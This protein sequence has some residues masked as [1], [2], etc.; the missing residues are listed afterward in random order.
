MS[1]G[2]ALA[3]LAAAID[4][5][6]TALERLVTL[7][8]TQRTITV[9]ALRG[10]TIEGRES[11]AIEALVAAGA[12]Q[13][14]PGQLGTSG[15]VDPTRAAQVGELLEVVLEARASAV[16]SAPAE[17]V[18][19][20]WTLPDGIVPDLNR[21]PPPRSLA[22]LLTSI[23]G[24]ATQRLV[25]LSPYADAAGARFLAGPLAGA[26]ARGVKITLV[27]HALD[28]AGAS[29]A[30]YA[31]LREAVPGMRAFSAYSPERAG[32]YLLLHAKLTVADGVRACVAS[33]NLTSYAMQTHLEVGVALGP[34]IAGQLE[35]VI[36][37]VIASP[38]VH[39]VR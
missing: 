28:E 16:R 11:L 22:A 17:P 39:P 23:I 38:L 1:R 29:A 18:E 31:V 20:A 14:L 24:A 25:L 36:E 3:R 15:V 26:A 37:Q 5:Q 34:P 33:G 32:T 13:R 10:I 2:A 21:G 6:P 8:Q 27:A 30:A 35:Q 4:D 7:L 9:A 12:I 19:L